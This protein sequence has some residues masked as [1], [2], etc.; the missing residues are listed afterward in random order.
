MPHKNEDQRLR[1]QIKPGVAMGICRPS[2]SAAKW[3]ET[4]ESRK[5]VGQASLE[6]AS[7]TKTVSQA[8]QKMRADT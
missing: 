4:G 5:L 1:P 8:R 6:N 7:V 2:S 3:E